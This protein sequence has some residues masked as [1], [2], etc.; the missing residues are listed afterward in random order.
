MSI[1]VKIISQDDNYTFDATVNEEIS[2]TRHLV[3]M[4]KDFFN[5]LNTEVNPEKV[6]E[7]S[8]LFLLTKEPKEM[9]YSKF[10][11]SIISSYYHDFLDYLSGKI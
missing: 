4:E 6:I 5:N 1:D 8:F 9:I 7:E 3:T 10:D 2:S 11:V